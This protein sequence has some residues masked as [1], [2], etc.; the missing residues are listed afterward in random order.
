MNI[1]AMICEIKQITAK[2]TSEY[3]FYEIDELNDELEK[4]THEMTEEMT[5]KFV[6]QKLK[7][8]CYR[9]ELYY[10]LA[11]IEGP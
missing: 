3:L 6:K 4:I 5:F 2:N 7:K 1:N 8:Q 11:L 9:L 10:G